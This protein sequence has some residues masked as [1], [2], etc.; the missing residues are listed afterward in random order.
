MSKGEIKISDVR[1]KGCGYCVYFCQHQCIAM[2]ADKFTV[3]GQILAEVKKP[4]ECTGCGICG[5]LCPDQAI[6]VYRLV[7]SQGR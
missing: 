5:W 4:E 1:C 2:S 3:G 7:E 6:E